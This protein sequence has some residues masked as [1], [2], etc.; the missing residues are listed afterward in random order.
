MIPDHVREAVETEARQ[1]GIGPF[2][3]LNL[4]NYQWERVG[5]TIFYDAIYETYG[6]KGGER[7]IEQIYKGAVI[8]TK[9]GGY[10]RL[11]GM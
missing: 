10:F 1:E 11:E 3:R 2:E 7:A 4:K 6:R 9:D 8:T 5:V